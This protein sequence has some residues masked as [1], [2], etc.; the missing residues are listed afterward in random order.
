MTWFQKRT[1]L[2]E[3]REDR[4]RTKRSDHMTPN[5]V[6][7]ALI[8]A[9]TAIFEVLPM[10]LSRSS[11]QSCA[12]PSAKVSS[13]TATRSGSLRLSSMTR[14]S[15]CRAPRP[16]SAAA[17]RSDHSAAGADGRACATALPETGKKNAAPKE[18]QLKQE[19]YDA[20][21][22]R[23]PRWAQRKNFGS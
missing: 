19:H 20:G 17:V 13:E 9:T 2:S 4:L 11:V 23:A 3:G 18:R 21:H 7:E 15:E 16:G 14:R 5:T 22:I 12:A 10:P 6:A 1:N 8:V